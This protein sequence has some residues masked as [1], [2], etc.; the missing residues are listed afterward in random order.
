MHAASQDL[1]CL[2]EVGLLPTRALRHRARRPAA[3]LPAGRPRHDDRADLRRPAAQGA[4]GRRLVDPAAADATGCATPRSTSSC[5]S[6]CAT[7]WPPSSTSRASGRGPSRSS[8]RWSPGPGVPARRRTDPWRRTS[9]IHRVRTR[10]GL[11]LVES[12]WYARDTIARRLDRAPG[13]ILPD[14]AISEVAESTTP[15]PGRAAQGPG[16]LPAPGQALRGRL[17]GRD[18]RGRAAARHRAAGP[19]PRRRRTRRRPGS[20]PRRTR[21][22][23]PGSPGSARRSPPAPRSSS[24]PVENLL[25]PEHV[26]RLTWT[27]PAELTPRVGRRRPRRLRRP[28]LAARA[29]RRPPHRRPRRPLTRPPHPSPPRPSRSVYHVHVVN[30]P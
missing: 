8:P 2:F 25:T 24:C 15:G 14:V 27:P 3:R 6:S 26:R 17:A 21:R 16:L 29:D 30:R 22:P 1:P 5:W 18:R 4:L 13:R 19:A 11:G 12:L 10:R 20:G 7:R 23:P 9:G 28:P